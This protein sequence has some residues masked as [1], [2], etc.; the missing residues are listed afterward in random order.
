M[1]EKYSDDDDSKKEDNF[2]DLLNS[3]INFE[4]KDENL[5]IDISSENKIFEE[6]E[7]NEKIEK[8]VCP[9]CGLIPNLEIES[10]NYTVKSNCPNCSN[11]I[12]NYRLVN[13]IK[14]S[15]ERIPKSIKCKGCNKTN[16]DLNI[17]KN[18]MF[19]CTCGKIFCESCK[20]KHEENAEEKNEENDVENH[21]E[22]DEEKD[23]EI[24]DNKNNHELI[25]FSEK[26]YQCKC[27]GN[28]S[29]Y[30]SFCV[31][32]N[33]NLCANCQIEHEAK[34]QGH[35]ILFFTEEIENHLTKDKIEEKKK[36]FEIKTNKIK[37]FI[38]DLDEW[39][40]EL[41]LKMEHLKHNLKLLMNVNNY[42]LNSFDKS[43]LNQ[44][45]I[46]TLN[47]L[48]FTYNSSIDEFIKN[49]GK[50]NSFE[51]RCQ[52]LI[53]LFNYQKNLNINFKKKKTIEKID[54]EDLNIL[55][56]NSRI[57][58]GKAEE[59]ITAVC[60]FGKGFAV[61]DIKGN[62]YFY[63]LDNNLKRLIKTTTIFDN[64]SLEIN[65]LCSLNDNIFISS[66]EDE[67]KIIKLYDSKSTTQY[68]VIKKFR[69][70][71]EENLRFLKTNRP[72]KNME[73]LIQNE[74]HKKELNNNISNE[75]L[76]I[77][78]RS[79]TICY[80]KNINN[81]KYY[82]ILKLLN[83]NIVYINEDKI[84]RLEPAFNNNYN[85]QCI[86]MAE[87]VICMVEINENKFCVY[88]EDNHFTIFD[89]N[90][91]KEIKDFSIKNVDNP[92]FLK[93][94]MIDQGTM[95]GMV[96]K[97]IFL[98]S[99]NKYCIVQ[100]IDT[101]KTIMDM[102]ITKSKK[103]LISGYYKN[104]NYIIQYNYKVLK[105]EISLSKSDIIDSGTRI[106]LLFLLD[107]KDN[108]KKNPYGRL[109][110]FHDNN[111]IKIYE[112]NKKNNKNIKN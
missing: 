51:F 48:D 14:K 83:D 108:N 15:N 91:F 70:K 78:Q 72:S 35:E 75:Q 2:Q 25:N 112:T 16:E 71:E 103:I 20:D 8:I 19:I 73:R 99:L 30:N 66:N 53:G 105:D 12:K 90:N 96:N 80:N 109:L 57:I 11:E 84:M 40:E 26:D 50:E 107:N 23:E 21:E 65:Y 111:L 94:K 102:I 34:N 42:I 93:I 31:T 44:Q 101:E 81:K 49:K 47:K 68:N 89:S 4:I 13:Y 22:N 79:P 86:E 27:K 59:T 98:I 41:E 33:Q 45:I 74:I 38:K 39:K 52:F 43:N 85:K 1:K 87:I 67:I 36:E 29:D 63:D 82:Q 32:C 54:L 88:S 55:K 6:I 64:N 61:G 9:D 56:N 10:Q 110:C 37:E 3:N 97:K 46:E 17:E 95:A 24:N 7:N 18:E 104:N 69:Y 76:E 60:Q 100:T 5:D 92:C 28:F 62:I 58:E 106:N 77:K